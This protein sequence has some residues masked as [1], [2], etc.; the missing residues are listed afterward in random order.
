MDLVEILPLHLCFKLC[1][2]K[3]LPSCDVFQSLTPSLQ[4][5]NG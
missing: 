4:F 2:S 5:M 3:S 1:M